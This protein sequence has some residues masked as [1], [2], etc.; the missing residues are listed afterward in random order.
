[1]SIKQDWF[2]TGFKTAHALSTKQDWFQTG[3]ETALKSSTK[4]DWFQECLQNKTYFKSAHTYSTKQDQFQKGF[5]T[6]T[7]VFTVNIRLISSVGNDLQV[8]VDLAVSG[9]DHPHKQSLYNE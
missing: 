9:M 6:L 3:F 8:V 1:M 7:V 2:E 4:Q 5:K